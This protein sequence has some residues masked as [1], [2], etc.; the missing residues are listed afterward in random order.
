MLITSPCYYHSPDDKTFGETFFFANVWWGTLGRHFAWDGV[1]GQQ[2]VEDPCPTYFRISLE[3]VMNQ[4]WSVP[5]RAHPVGTADHERALLPAGCETCFWGWGCYF[6]SDV[7]TVS[8]LVVCYW[9][10]QLTRTAAA[11]SAALL[12]SPATYWP[13]SNSTAW[14]EALC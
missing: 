13:L 14:W 12:Y 4:S 8:L 2:K 11:D 1:H 6:R 7:W 10:S 3:Q 5:A 9:L